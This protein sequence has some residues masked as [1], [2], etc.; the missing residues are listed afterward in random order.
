M[1]RVEVLLPSAPSV[2]RRDDEIGLLM[3]ISSPMPM[4]SI[5]GF[6]VQA[7][8]WGCVCADRKVY[9]KYSA[10]S[11]AYTPLKGFSS[12]EPQWVLLK[13]FSELILASPCFTLVRLVVCLWRSNGTGRAASCRSLVF[14]AGMILL[15][16]CSLMAVPRIAVRGRAFAVQED[17]RAELYRLF[18]RS[19][20][21]TEI[22]EG[23]MMSVLVI[24]PALNE[25]KHCRRDR[26]PE[27]ESP[28]TCCR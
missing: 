12:G 28:D 22:A 9:Y 13:Y 23:L 26:R 2:A 4:M 15:A 24:I 10:S 14:K 11:S 3:R 19:L 21:V 16:W 1:N 5:S 8:G 18:V 25:G 27:R 17:R 7:C 6:P 20:S